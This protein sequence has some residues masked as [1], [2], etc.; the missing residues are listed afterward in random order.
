MTIIPEKLKRNDEVRV[1]APAQSIRLPFITPEVIKIATKRIKELGLKLTFGKHVK[2]LNYFNSSSIK[3]RVEDIHEAFKD[4]NVKMIIT[5]IGGYNSGEVLPYLDY[6]LIKENPKILCGYSDITA[7]MT[8]IHTK[9]SLVT[10]Y[11]PHFFDFGEKKGFDYTLE[12]FKK[13]L[14]NNEPFD[15]VPSKEWS[16]DRWANDQENRNFMKN[17]GFFLINEGKAR[18]V[19]LGGNLVTFHS[20]SGTHYFPE[21]KNTILFLEEDEE[22]HLLTFNR[23]LNALTLRSDFSEVKAIVFGRFQPESKITKQDLIEIVRANERLQKIPIVANVDFGHTTPK[24]TFPI[25]GTC[26]ITAKE[27]EIKITIDKH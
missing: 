24:I 25:G 17:E 19:I 27:K 14:F 8:G 26:K 12:Y 23:N 3:S 22:E 9:T 6:D 10:Y 21:F 4:P 1:V 11:G 13:C 20:L 5:V 2:E 18:G 15:V 16:N 7:L